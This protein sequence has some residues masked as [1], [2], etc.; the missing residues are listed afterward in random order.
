MPIRDNEIFKKCFLGDT[1]QESKIL[2]TKYTQR[3]SMLANKFSMITGVDRD[4]LNSEGI[5]GLARA[6]RDFD[7]TRS[8][9][10]TIFALYKIK[11]AMNEFIASQS[12]NFHIPRYIIEAGRLANQLKQ[13]IR[14]SYGIEIIS[15]LSIWKMSV[16][17]TQQ[18]QRVSDIRLN[19]KNLAIRSHLTTNK[20]LNRVDIHPITN[21]KEIDDVFNTSEF[22][23][24]ANPSAEKIVIVRDLITKI[25]EV[26]TEKEKSI[27]ELYFEKGFTLREIAKKL[28]RKPSTI[29]VNVSK[30]KGKLM[31]AMKN[32]T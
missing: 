19:I 25:K 26:L 20:L 11:G 31:H 16:K 7:I 32:I 28:S 22:K 3:I 13:E 1:E 10:F 27:F 12:K 8:T 15:A 23:K 14:K 4:D 21:T 24:V 30:Q 17:Y 18:N 5:I 6:N 29:A 2:L 9:N